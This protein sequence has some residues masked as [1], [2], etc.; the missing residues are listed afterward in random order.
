MK[1]IKIDLRAKKPTVKDGFHYRWY[2]HAKDRFWEVVHVAPWDHQS[3]CFD[4]P[5]F[6][7]YEP[8]YWVSE[9]KVWQWGE[10]VEK[11]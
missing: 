4:R 5:G 3:M 6:K 9:T 8:Y 7:E 11:Q 1:N 2:R 10:R